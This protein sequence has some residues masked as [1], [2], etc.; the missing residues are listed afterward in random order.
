VSLEY[1]EGDSR[2][3]G[4]V[5]SRH[6]EAPFSGAGPTAVQLSLLLHLFNLRQI[7]TRSVG[8]MSGG[9]NLNLTNCTQMARAI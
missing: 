5:V 8:F 6:L 4:K 2:K 3:L 1:G 7:S 9:A